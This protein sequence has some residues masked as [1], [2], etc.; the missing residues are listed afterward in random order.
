MS[1]DWT[2]TKNGLPEENRLVEGMDSKGHVQKFVR[3]GNLW[4]FPDMSSYAYF[5]PTHWRYI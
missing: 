4:F 2:V 3:Q 5:T 1:R